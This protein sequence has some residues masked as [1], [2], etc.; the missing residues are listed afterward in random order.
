MITCNKLLTGKDI[1]YEGINHTDYR[2]PSCGHVT[3]AKHDG[4]ADKL[5]QYKCQ[6]LVSDCNAKR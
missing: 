6:N 3:R 2:C 1:V 5:K 4:S